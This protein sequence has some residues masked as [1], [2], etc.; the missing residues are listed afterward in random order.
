MRTITKII[1]ALLFALPATSPAQ[2][3]NNPAYHSGMQLS[4]EYGAMSKMDAMQ[5]FGRRYRRN[6][7]P[8]PDPHKRKLT[9]MGVRETGN[10]TTFAEYEIYEG[11]IF[12]GNNVPMASVTDAD[13]NTYMTGGSS[14]PDHPGGDFF[15]L[16]DN[17]TGEIA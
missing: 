14:N 8:D 12:T 6:P 2:D 1:S 7:V 5:Q 16:K 17:A 11:E 3:T 10:K 15:T 9:A 13:G 4:A